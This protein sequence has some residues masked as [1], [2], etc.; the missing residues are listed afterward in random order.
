MIR[1]G[2]KRFI[3]SSILQLFGEKEPKKEA[4]KRQ[5]RQDNRDGQEQGQKSRR[6]KKRKKNRWKEEEEGWEQMYQTTKRG[7]KEKKNPQEKYN[8]SGFFSS[9]CKFS[10]RGRNSSS[11]KPYSSI[12]SQKQG[13]ECGV[14]ARIIIVNLPKK[15]TKVISFIFSRY[16]ENHCSSAPRLPREKRPNSSPAS[17]KI[18]EGISFSIQEVEDA[19]PKMEEGASLSLLHV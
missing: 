6:K 17:E 14:F 18:K 9:G 7:K 5:K 12:Y 1:Y 16:G 2:S 8:K 19:S 3:I 13:S 11:N 4:E 15:L 10:C